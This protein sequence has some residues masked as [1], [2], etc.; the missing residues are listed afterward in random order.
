MC[1]LFIINFT[2]N[3]EFACNDFVV[4][5]FSGKNDGSVKGV[6]YFSCG[7]KRGVF[8]RPDKVLLDKRG[9]S[10]RN[11]NPKTSTENNMIMRKSISK[12]S[13][14][15]KC[16]FFPLALRRKQQAAFD[17][18]LK[19]SSDLSWHSVEILYFSL[20][21]WISVKSICCWFAENC[22]L[23][24]GFGMIIF[25]LITF[26]VNQFA[27]SPISASICEIVYHSQ[28]WFHVKWKILRFP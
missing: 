14:P 19:Q 2:Q 25:W 9:R 17:L 18:F 23:F 26:H 3:I 7:A 20:Q 24:R 21:L 12:G 13:Y 1:F 22:P 5:Y 8:V 11:N 6:R 4:P 28:S 27:T 16:Y 10:V 15:S